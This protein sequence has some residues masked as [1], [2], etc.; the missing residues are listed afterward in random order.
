MARE[1]V[2]SP[3]AERGTGDVNEAASFGAVVKPV[4]SPKGSE[5]WRV[6]KV[7]RLTADENR[8]KHN[9]FVRAIDSAGNRVRDDRLR[10]VWTWEGRT[11][12]QDARPAALDKGDADFGHADVPIEKGMHTTVRLEGDGLDS[13]QVANLHTDHNI[14]EK[15]SDGVEGNYWFHHSYLVVFQRQ[16]V[17]VAAPPAKPPTPAEKP[18]TPAK[19]PAP[20]PAPVTPSAPVAIPAGQFAI[21]AWPAPSRTFTQYFGSNPDW[22]VPH[23]F[24]GHEGIDLDADVGDPIVA[25]AD[26]VVHMAHAPATGHNYGTHLRINHAGGYQTIYAH[27]S[28]LHVQKDQQVKAGQLIGLAGSSGNSTGPHL[29]FSLKKANA[30]SPGYPGNFIDPLPFLLAF[31]QSNPQPGTSVAA[32]EAVSVSPTA[33]ASLPTGNAPSI[34]TVAAESIVV[35]PNASW[36]ARKAGEFW[37]KHG[38]YL[39][40]ECQRLGIDPADAI[41]VI[42]TESGGEPFGP[43]GRMTIRF[44]NHIFHS[45]WGKSNPQRFNDHFTFDANERWK[46]HTWRPS[47]GAAWQQCHSSQAVEWQVLDFARTLDNE[48]ALKS[49]SMGAGQVMGF[50]HETVGYASAQAM[51]DAFSKD[52]SAQIGAM[53]R[54]MEKNQLVES[55]RKQ[56]YAAFAR[57]YNGPGQATE[58]ATRMRDFAD[59]F[60]SLNGAPAGRDAQ[61]ATPATAAASVPEDAE[62]RSPMPDPIP[63]VPLKEADPE[64]YAAWSKHI[65]SGFEQNEIMFGRVLNAFMNPYWMTV[66]MYGILFAI[67]VVTLAVTIYLS[68]RPASNPVTTWLIAG[69]SIA[70]FAAF[71]VRRP[72]QS[73]EENLQFITWLGIIYNTYWTTLVNSQD[74]RTFV[75]DL[76]KATETA[77]TRIKEL[78]DAHA[79]RSKERPKMEE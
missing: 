33:T 61:T 8:G 53:F 28:A 79:A 51:F 10:V 24:A 3:P 48:A 2:V 63:G 43:D 38:A 46:G 21:A 44:E 66:V 36:S 62:A 76:E 17:Q 55:V 60:R 54:F 57:V 39:A 4:A 16:P 35:P 64:L 65:Q 13:D 73:L 14:A 78:S 72:L 69:M 77:I 70:A 6:V 58:Y 30:E 20:A 19:P 5:C 7:R 15:T 25:V 67:G 68:L 41:G 32:N 75:R 37:N 29:H 11:P 50:N 42:V 45:Y 9:V 27:L 47:T 1:G 26:G 56:D 18:T 12:D 34:S 59:A 71:F 31:A 22:Y 74:R 23:G 49:I 52:A 40:N